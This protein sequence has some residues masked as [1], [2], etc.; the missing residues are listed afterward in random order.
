MKFE[1]DINDQAL[2]EEPELEQFAQAL[3]FMINRMIVSHFKY[4][5]MS[6]K[7]PDSASGLGLVEQR[8]DLYKKSGNIEFCLDAANGAIIEFLYPGHE[9]AHHEARETR[10]VSPGLAWKED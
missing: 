6:D 1:I 3:Q 5:N 10:T 2:K 8:V 9:K 7:Y 4:G